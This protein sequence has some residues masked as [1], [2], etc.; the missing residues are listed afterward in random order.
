MK[1]KVI[2]FMPIKGYG[3]ISGFD[4]QSYFVHQTEILMDGFRFLE[5]GQLV[6]FRPVKTMKGYQATRVKII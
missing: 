3:F 4:E 1:G 5:A 6:D 2:M